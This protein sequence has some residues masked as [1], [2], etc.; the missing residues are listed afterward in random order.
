MRSRWR[1]SA[2]PALH[3]RPARRPPADGRPRRAAGR[4]AAIRPRAVDRGR[5]LK[6]A[7]S[8]L[9]IYRRR[10]GHRCDAA[11]AAGRT[12]RS[13]AATVEPYGKWYEP[14]RWSPPTGPWPR[15]LL[16]KGGSGRPCVLRIEGVA[17][18]A[19]ARNSQLNARIR[20]PTVTGSGRRPTK[21]RPD[22]RFSGRASGLLSRSAWAAG[23]SRHC[24]S[25]G[26]RTDCQRAERCRPE[27]F[28]ERA[29]GRRRAT[30]VEG[31]GRQ[32][33]IPRER[34]SLSVGIPGPQWRRRGRHRRMDAH[35][36]K[37]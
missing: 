14:G 6:S 13:A 36:R 35:Q 18:S 25:G 9:R 5:G 30:E 37:A 19:D 26:Q 29:G 2:R 21:G 22:R 3:R 7:V 10:C 28:V 16:E 33:P 11:G 20:E 23:H 1:W 27:R 15:R 8:E 34:P 31:P 4:L 17:N 24:C 32:R 12:S